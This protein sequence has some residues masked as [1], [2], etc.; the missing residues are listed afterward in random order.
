MYDDPGLLIPD[1]WSSHAVLPS[2]RVVITGAGVV[3]PLGHDLPPSGRRSPPARAASAR[4]ARS[5][6]A[7]LPFRIAG[8]VTGFDAEEACRPKDERK[9]LKLMARSVQMGVAARQVRVRPTAGLDRAS[10][11]RPASASSSARA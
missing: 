4:S 6:P 9:S 8:E 5:T 11:T 1:S 2:R 10:S 3:T 7:T